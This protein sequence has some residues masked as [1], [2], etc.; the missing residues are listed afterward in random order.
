MTRRA[1]TLLW[2]DNLEHVVDA[3]ARALMGWLDAGDHCFLVTSQ[4]AARIEGEHVHAV[5]PLGLEDAQR[6]LRVRVREAAPEVP[7]D[8]PAVRELAERL[9]RLPLAIEL[10]AS[11]ARL[12]APAELLAR[13]DDRFAL[14]RSRQ[15]DRG[16]R[17]ATSR[18]RSSGP[19]SC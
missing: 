12:L 4:V 15:R 13:L 17:H 7:L 8:E 19:T 3:G 18:R 9:D 16:A 14:L 10:A 6:L 11:R 2:L 5:E 1:P